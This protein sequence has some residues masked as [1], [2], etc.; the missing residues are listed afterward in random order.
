M[1]ARSP[2][3][4]SAEK[5]DPC[6]NSNRKQAW[7]VPQAATDDVVDMADELRELFRLADEASS[8]PILTDE[9]AEE[10]PFDEFIDFGGGGDDAANG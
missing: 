3:V 5:G 4:S 2:I 8:I 6:E 9:A 1:R 7:F 10:Q